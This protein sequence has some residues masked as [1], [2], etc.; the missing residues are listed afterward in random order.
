MFF[1]VVILYNYLRK[2]PNQLFC[3]SLSFSFGTR[4]YKTCETCVEC[5]RVRSPQPWLLG[6][7]NPGVVVRLTS[8]CLLQPV[9]PVLWI[10]SMDHHLQP[11]LLPALWAIGNGAAPPQG[12][13]SY[14]GHFPGITMGWRPW[15]VSKSRKACATVTLSVLFFLLPS[16]F[17]SI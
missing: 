2:Q 3:E 8:R 15:W 9:R 13:L 14:P 12:W 6:A 17:S 4:S 10:S 5:H 1:V 11:P 7:W 16:S